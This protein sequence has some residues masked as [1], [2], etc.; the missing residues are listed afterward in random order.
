[1]TCH[2]S[3]HFFW[4]NERMG[5]R[6]KERK[7]KKDNK[8]EKEKRCKGKRHGKDRHRYMLNLESRGLPVFG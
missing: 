8:R 3:F 1:M 5:G 7:E 4:K 6:E 2:F